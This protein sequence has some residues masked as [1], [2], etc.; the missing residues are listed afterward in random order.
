MKS[1]TL[2]LLEETMVYWRAK[3]EVSWAESNDAKVGQQR[4]FRGN[5]RTPPLIG[6][7]YGEIH[8]KGSG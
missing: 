5:R 3:G 7:M 2:R 4:T 1:P 8:G 6:S